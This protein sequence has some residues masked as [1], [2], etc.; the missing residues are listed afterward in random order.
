MTT[1]LDTLP[2]D[3][4]SLRAI[5]V[6]RD[7]ELAV[8]D[9]ALTSRDAELAKLHQ[10]IADLRHNVEVY[11]KMAFGPSSEKRTPAKPE[12][13][14]QGHLFFAELIADAERT[15]REKNLAGSI[16]A[17][18]GKPRK[19]KGGRRK[20]FPEH[21]PRVTTRF[22]LPE[23]Q[24][25]CKCG[26]PFH[27]IGCETTRELERIEVT[28]VHI[29][30][31]AKYACRKCENG[32]MTA[33]GP[34]R[35]FEKGLL[36]VGFLANL[37]TERFGNHMPYNRLEKKYANEGMNLSRS[38]LERSAARCAKRLKPLYDLL[39]EQVREADVLFTDDTPVTIARPGDR[40]AGSKQGRIWIYL[41]RDGR[42]A[43]DFSDSRKSDVPMAWLGDYTGFVHADA[44]P[45]YDRAFVPGGATEVACWAHTRRKF[46]D[47]EKTEPELSA[48]VLSRIRELYAI[49][50][51]AKDN[52]LPDEDRQQLR[53]EK[54]MP[55]LEELRAR[56][57]VL[58]SKALPKSP[59]GRAI[60]YATR[61]WTA[62]TTYTTDGR[63]SIDNNAAE[64]ALRSYAVGRKNWMFFQRD[65]GGE[66]SAIVMSLLKTAE[67]AGVN[68]VTWFRDVLVRIDRER[69]FEKLLPHG[70]KAH[71]ESEVEGARLEVVQRFLNA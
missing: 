13:V 64:R 53:Q 44:Y 60:G 22:E 19:K 70:W 18:A 29:I 36:G 7:A 8:R 56:L 47:A 5:V 39:S 46:V 23:D 48:E 34:D 17:T 12:H 67:A 3:T 49:E 27:E 9:A 28:L 66:T 31:R 25:T 26:N 20:D 2:N 54:A 40:A 51:Y 59:L 42:H 15:A 35:P 30:E 65:G 32:V 6:E 38:V 37:L 62:L 24:R 11:R 61:Q 4:Q 16:S 14:N 41:D 57:D 55:I 52:E 45:G 63:L 69:D 33:A 43:Y 58:E 68:P 10:E 1:P 71:F 50:R 21:L